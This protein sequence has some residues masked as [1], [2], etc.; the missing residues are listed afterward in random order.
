MFEF[1]E[2]DKL[3][4]IVLSNKKKT[5]KYAAKLPWFYRNDTTPAHLRSFM[6]HKANATEIQFMSSKD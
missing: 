4:Y 5:D 1:V 6:C 3:W 2:Y